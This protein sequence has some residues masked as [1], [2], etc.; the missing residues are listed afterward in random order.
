MKYGP[1]IL[2]PALVFALGCQTSATRASRSPEYLTS[3][4]AAGLALPFSEAVRAGDFLFV[5]GQIGNLPGKRELVPGGIGPEAA[6]ALENIKAILERHGSSMDDVVKC[7]VFLADI[8][9]WPAFNEVYRRSFTN[10]FPARSALAASGLVLGARVEV[11]CIA[12]SP[13]PVR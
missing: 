5:S 8:R 2:F 9:E 7:T 13:S 10:H 6:R 1:V 3:P 11:E 12:H 4:D